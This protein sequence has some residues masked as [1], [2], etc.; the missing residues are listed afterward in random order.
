MAQDYDVCC[1]VHPRPFLIRRP[2]AASN[3]RPSAGRIGCPGR[4]YADQVFQGPLG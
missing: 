3:P 1:I 2:A 4:A